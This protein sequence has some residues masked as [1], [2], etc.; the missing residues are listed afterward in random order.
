M[1]Y[2]L[3]VQVH[4][5]FNVNQ[6]IQRRPLI[7]AAK[8][9]VVSV[10]PLQSVQS[11]VESGLVH[12]WQAP[13]DDSPSDHCPYIIAHKQKHLQPMQVGAEGGLVNW[14]QAPVAHRSQLP[15]QLLRR[16][17]KRTQ[18]HAESAVCL[19]EHPSCAL[20]PRPQLPP[21]ADALKRLSEAVS[22]F[23][24]TPMLCRSTQ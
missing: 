16:I 1:Q 24:A 9:N 7:E 10:Q 21:F 12:S 18:K 6:L 4:I 11:G 14:L 23:S 3:Q 22:C 5:H 2:C 13:L 20:P 15:A 17:T 8:Q 19:C